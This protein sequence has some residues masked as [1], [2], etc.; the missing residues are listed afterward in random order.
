MN[1]SFA[2][3]LGALARHRG[4]WASMVVGE[5]DGM[6][7]DSNLQI[8]QNGDR[9]AALTASLYRKAHL[10][11]AKAGL[12]TVAFLQLEA[13]DGRGY[14]AGR[15]DL[16]LIVVTAHAANVGLVRLEMLRAAGGGRPSTLPEGS[17]GRS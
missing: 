11:A 4:V 16:V 17:W 6:I 8:G 2:E 13:E 14:A 1:T 15:N 5:R 7:V 9:V 10:S 12:G 3:M